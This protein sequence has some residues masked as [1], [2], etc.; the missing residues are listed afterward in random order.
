MSKEVPFEEY[1]ASLLK[2]L[3]DT[4]DQIKKRYAWQPG[5]KLRMIFHQ[6]FK[7]YK[8]AEASAVKEFVDAIT[9]FDVE[10]AF[11]HISRSHPWKV[12]DLKSSGINHWENGKRET[13]GEYVPTRGCCVPL[14]PNAALLCLTGPPQLK[15]PLQGCPEPIL[16]SLHRESTFHSLDY[17]VEQIFKLTFMSWRSFFPATMPVTVYYSNLI[18][19]IL[20]KLKDIPHWNP[21]ILLTKLRESAWFL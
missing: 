17:V 20:G 5:D 4:L 8:D 6:T 9:D 16:V 18:A 21:D 3:R 13:K 11:V 12:F 1:Q 19:E 7:K 14:G 15:T 10:Y 2:V